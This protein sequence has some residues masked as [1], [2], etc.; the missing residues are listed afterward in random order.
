MRTDWVIA[1][2]GESGTIVWTPLPGI[3]KSIVF[4]CPVAALE[5]RIA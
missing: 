1:G 2:S 5:S 3:A 4:V